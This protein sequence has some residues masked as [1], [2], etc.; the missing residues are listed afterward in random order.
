[1]KYS[2]TGSWC[3]NAGAPVYLF[4]F[5]ASCNWESECN[6]WADESGHNCVN[7]AWAQQIVITEVNTHL[8]NT[9]VGKSIKHL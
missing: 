7:S 6:V 8:G 9:Y 5:G 1:M 2:M 3:N 4:T